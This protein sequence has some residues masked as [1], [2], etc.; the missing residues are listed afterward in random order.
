MPCIALS[1]KRLR[2]LFG[3]AL[4]FALTIVSM[5]T[6]ISP[7]EVSDTSSSMEIIPSLVPPKPPPPEDWPNRW[8]Q[9]IPCR[10]P[11]WEGIM[12]GQTAAAEAVEILAQSPV[13]ATVEMTISPLIPEDGYVT[14]TWTGIEGGGQA[15]FHAQA[16][17]ASIYLIEPYYPTSFRLG[18]VIQAYGEP[19]HIIARSYHGPDI[20]SGIFYDLR[21][22]YRSQGFLLIDG[23]PNKPVLDADT[24]FERVVFFALSD[25]GLQAALAG[26]AAYPEWLN[27]WQ[28]IKNF[29]FY[30]RDEA[31][32]PCP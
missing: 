21:I 13:I 1:V 29:D 18:D 24:R 28:G 7:P 9:G 22:V 8:I 27:P 17:A 26:A 25:E 10:P 16:P 19:S 32:E 6:C 11:C 23:G 14:W 30:C 12:P 15:L 20:G 31:G 4:V 5:V 3:C 2:R